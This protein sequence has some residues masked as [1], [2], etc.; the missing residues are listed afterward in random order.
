MNAVSIRPSGAGL[1]EVMLSLTLGALVIA[2]AAALLARSTDAI[3]AADTNARMQEV[4]RYAMAILATDLRMAGYWG[5]AGTDVAVVKNAALAFPPKCGGVAWLGD[6]GRY[7]AGSNDSFLPL[8]ACTASGGGHKPGTDVLIVRRASSRRLVPQS[9][10]V[11]TANRNRVLIESSRQAAE[12]FVPQDIGNVIP[13]GYA[14][15]D[16]AGTAPAADTREFEVNAYYVSVGSSTSPTHPS[17]RR[18]SLVAGPDIRDEEIIA[19]IEDLQLR[20]GV[21]EDGDGNVD[22]FVAPGSEPAEAT[23]VSVRLWLLVRSQDRDRATSAGRTEEYAGHVTPDGS[24]GLRRL[25]VS[26]TVQLRNTRP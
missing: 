3:E 1:V 13:A 25:L 21:D 2:A 10:T 7:V 24:D 17:L 15:S 6:T 9:A 4:A 22:G 12:I 8:P 26:S 14:V 20:F 19:G 11:A 16:V 5:L 18:K 23:I